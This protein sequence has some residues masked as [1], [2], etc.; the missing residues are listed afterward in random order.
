[1]DES[2]LMVTICVARSNCSQ[3]M[4][5]LDWTRYSILTNMGHTIVLVTASQAVFL[6]VFS[7]TLF[8]LGRRTKRD[9]PH[10]GY[11]IRYPGHRIKW[12]F[13]ALLAFVLLTSIGEGILTDETYRANGYTTQPH[14]YIPAILALAL[15]GFS[16][17]C[18]QVMETRQLPS[19][20]FLLVTYWAVSIMAEAQQLMSIMRLIDDGQALMEV[21][22]FDLIL[23]RLIFYSVLLVVELNAIRVKVLCGGS[24]QD[25]K[26]PRELMSGD[27]HYV[28]DYVNLGSELSFS[29]F[30][31]LLKLGYKRPLEMED[32]GTLPE[33]HN[34]RVKHEKFYN[35]FEQEKEQKEKVGKQPSLW[36]VFTKVH[37]WQIFLSF[38]LRLIVELLNFVGPFCVGGITLYITNIM[39]PTSEISSV[40]SLMN[41]DT[42][43]L[44]LNVCCIQDGK[45][46]DVKTVLPVQL[47]VIPDLDSHGVSWCWLTLRIYFGGGQWW[48]KLLRR[49]DGRWSGGAKSTSQAVFLLV[50]SL[51]LFIL[52]RRTKRDHPHSGYFIRYPGHRIKWLFTALLA[53][54]L[55]TSIGEGI[56]TD[57]TYRANGYTTQPHLYIPAILALAS[58]GFSLACY[59]VMETRQL[60]SMAFL[61]VT[62]WAVSIMA[63]AQQLMSIMRLIDD[64]QALM[65]VMRFDLI[66]CRLIFYSVLLVVELNAIR[67]K[68]LCGGSPQD[69]KLPR[70]LASGDMHY[71][72]DYVNLGSE[73]SFSWFNWLLK[74]GY[75]R[76][77]EMEDLGTLPEA[78]NTRV[79]HERFYNA[80]EQEKT[81][82][83]VSVNAYFAN[84]FALVA[85]MFMT[86]LLQ[87]FMW[88]YYI[89][90]TVENCIDIGASFRA[91]IYQKSLKLS[92]FATTGG[93]ST[94]GEIT[95]H[96]STDCGQITW[97]MHPG[98]HLIIVPI[99]M[100]C[101]LVFLYLQMGYSVLV[102]AVAL[103]VFLPAHAVVFRL[104]VKGYKEKEKVSDERLKR[105]NEMLNGM[106]LLK[107]YGWEEL[108]CEA[109]ESIRKKELW[110]MVKI[111]L[112]IVLLI[113]I[114]MA[115]PVAVTLVAFGLYEFVQN[116]ALTPAV[117]FTS[118][119]LFN[120]L[121]RP[122]FGVPGSATGVLNAFVSIKR[123]QEFLNA[124]EVETRSKRH[125]KQHHSQN[126]KGYNVPDSNCNLKNGYHKLTESDHDEGS[127]VHKS[128]VETEASNGLPNLPHDTAVKIEHGS[129]TWDQNSAT[130]VLDDIQVNIPA[131]KLTIVVG[132]VGSGKSSLLSAI[133]GEMTTLK[134]SVQFNSGNISMA[135]AAQKPWLLN[136]SLKDNI[137]FGQDMDSCK[138]KKCMEACALQTDLDILPAG[139]DTEIGE[140]GINLSG[141]Q[142]QRVSVARSLYSGRDIIVL[143]D[144]LSAL[145]VHVGGHL[146]QEGIMGMLVKNKQTVILVTHQLQFLQHAD[147]V[148][149]MKDGKIQHQGTLEEI[150][151]KDPNL[152]NTWQDAIHHAN[153]SEAASEKS[154]E[155]TDSATGGEGEKTKIAKEESKEK[156]VTPDAGKL[157]EEEDRERGSVTLDVYLYYLKT[158]GAVLVCILVLGLIVRTSLGMGST[159]W[160]ST[161][162]EASLKNDTRTTKHFIMGYAGISIVAILSSILCYGIQI[163]S[164][165]VAARKLHGA[166][167]RNIIRAPMRFF[168]TTPIGRVLNR[169]SGDVS[170]IDMELLNTINELLGSLIPC[171]AALVV[172]VIVGPFFI[173]VLVPASIAYYYIQKMFITAAR[174]LQRMHNIT[175][176]PI[177]AYF[178][179][180]LSGLSTIRAYKDQK[181][182]Y[183]NMIKK[184]NTNLTA[185]LYMQTAHRWLSIRLDLL[186][187]MVVF[188]AGLSTVLGALYFGLEPAMAG[189]AITYTLEIFGYLSCF[190]RKSAFLELEMNSVERVKRY[191]DVP[192]EEY[193]GTEPPAEW[194]SEGKISLENVSVRYAEKLDPVLKG[195]SVVFKPGEKI[196]I[197]GRTGSGKSS[198]TLAL[199]R[200]IDTYE[201]RIVIDGVDVA[202]VPLT[203]LRQRLSIIPQDPVLLTGTI[204]Q[205][206]DPQKQCTDDEM[207]D[208]L[209]IAQLKDIVSELED[210]LDSKVTEGGENF[211]VGQ[212]QLFCLA[213]AFLRKS[214]I[215]VMDEATASI[216]MET[217]MMLQKVVATAFADR[218]VLTIAHRIATIMDSDT[219]LVLSQGKVVECDSPQNLLAREDSEFSSLVRGHNE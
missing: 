174:E 67:V 17:A 173:L 43:Y 41:M 149:V 45:S 199:F 125:Q 2:E 157:I 194:P 214:R 68:V 3:D 51:T 122:L 169:F 53:F 152:Y 121:T 185:Q 192:S 6:L 183:D 151:E 178:S 171:I 37:G 18:Y 29:W 166:M 155:E 115:T 104:M 110:A 164:S 198:L 54:V 94:M 150:Q 36:K 163:T 132:Q 1:M 42:T 48:Y 12:L 82:E 167:L 189:L 137:L 138:Y 190:V 24:P 143:D 84:G 11:F 80:F 9:H 197:C 215:L 146:F 62:Y 76:P 184:L 131:G 218:T 123:V 135:Y 31:W 117:A 65:E 108:Y 147:L 201:G 134:G 204:R 50:F 93:K 168:D 7:L 19:M 144:P 159:F 113:T 46:K 69:D 196:G 78:H 33:A 64:G 14:L 127:N 38:V 140:K 179:E 207:W 205:N 139:D 73:L 109:I 182:F 133:L 210:G 83:F 102:A 59:Q 148:I 103:L 129:F 61:L 52:G 40:S 118:L 119:A 66:L 100:I 175:R 105:S 60:P 142:K 216:D 160:L 70:E 10:S 114:S 188:V 16:L 162:S 27:M 141:G 177:F 96:M 13:T 154:G 22:R 25:D 128:M 187:A 89:H 106:K 126:T 209:T 15:L 55:L 8:I 90:W 208:A 44:G 20:A 202:T 86:D 165:L 79:K 206:L 156:K 219:I 72:Q 203:T 74:L 71:V 101:S 39:Y 21:M 56:L 92:T 193:D 195:V 63:E 213:R 181:H 191:T 124:P 23:C 112:Y 211:S 77:L 98:H 158:I 153:Y 95:N 200:M 186:G 87:I 81:P 217:D 120:Q 91:M 58:L 49:I 97:M 32:L 145:D 180:S 88:Q 111:S 85:T 26:L 212:R 35:A 30:N 4:N 47:Q 130:A 34:T 170:C 176:S 28:Q 107:L 172:N 99:Q 5:Y 75:K 116:V 57:E 161:W 136:A